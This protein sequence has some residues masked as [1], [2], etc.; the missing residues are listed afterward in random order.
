MDQ[1]VQTTRGG[2]DWAHLFFSSFGR[3]GRIPFAGGLL[4]VLALFAAFDL[5][6]AGWVRTV[7]AWA[8]FTMLLFSGCCLLAKRLHDRGRSGWWAGAIW[9]AF[10]AAWPHAE[11]PFG[12]A[13]AVVLA[14]A[15]V[16]L[17][18]LPGQ[19]EANRFGPAP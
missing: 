6:S 2:Q 19:R 7:S 5:H 11:G 17:L 14:V 13:G 10:L 9:I 12:P 16:D 18:L 4:L 3:I 15:A 1:R 8:V